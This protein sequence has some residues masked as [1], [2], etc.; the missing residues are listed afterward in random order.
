[1]NKRKLTTASVSFVLFVILTG[2]VKTFDVA[3]I[4][5]E[6]T[7]IGFS[8]INGA[9]NSFFGL[10]MLWYD[11]TE[12]LGYLAIAIAL[13]MA[14]AGARQLIKRK[15]FLAVDPELYGLAGLYVVTGVLY[16][17][18]EKIIVNYRPVIL[19][20]ESAP[21]ASFPSSHTMLAC[22]IFGSAVVMSGI[23]IE[24]KNKQLSTKIVLDILIFVTV[25]GRLISGVHWL[26]DIVGGVLISVTLVS[27]FSAFVN[28]K[29]TP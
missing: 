11:I 8:H 3:P 19:P 20:D 27:L 1:M 16:V 17:L 18:F 24:E 5:P 25:F 4:G 9:V 15:S 13:I 29:K 23:Y 6:G 12:A 22:V 28:R 14:A 26:T 10:N 7:E 21:E 2:L